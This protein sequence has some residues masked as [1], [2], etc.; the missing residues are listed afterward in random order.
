MPQRESERLPSDLP[1]GGSRGSVASVARPLDLD[2]YCGRIGHAHS[3]AAD[4]DTLRELHR[5]HVGSV[6]FENLDIQL[7]MPIILELEQLVEKIVH[8]RRGGYC[9]EQNTLFLAVLREL[10]FEAR[11]YEARVRLGSTEPR[12][13]THMLI[14]VDVGGAEYLADVGFGGDGVLEPLPMDGTTV[15]Q[16]GRSYRVRSEGGERVLQ[17]EQAQ[18]WLDLYAFVPESRPAVD[19][20]M[21][22]H[23]TSTHPLSPFV[24]TL[25]VQLS[26]PDERHILRN[27]S[28]VVVREGGS[29]ERALEERE[30]LSLIRER[31]G[32]D[33]PEG[34]RLRAFA[35]SSR[36]A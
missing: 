26:R 23:F 33:L 36:P 32:L 15:V 8:R 34:A 3:A 16:G 14:G 22:N 1:G 20:E 27:R 18:G 35:A 31:F 10:G 30:V 24:R 28:Y 5:R 19:F 13:R 11:P 25:T 12:P 17:L 4:L 21:A 9:F 2:A 29:E 7:G 6:P